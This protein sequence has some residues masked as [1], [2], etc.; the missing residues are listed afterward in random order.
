MESKVCSNTYYVY[1]SSRAE[2]LKVLLL[3]CSG[4]DHQIQFLFS[5]RR[6]GGYRGQGG[7]G[8]GLDIESNEQQ[9]QCMRAICDWQIW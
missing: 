1:N 3:W 7:L 8:L 9:Q 6:D 5:R 4:S 2:F